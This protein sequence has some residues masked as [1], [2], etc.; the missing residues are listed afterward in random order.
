MACDELTAQGCLG[1]VLDEGR[2]VVGLR[3]VVVDGSG[4]K[5]EG[6]VR[7]ADVEPPDDGEGDEQADEVLADGTGLERALLQVLE[8]VA[9]HG[10]AL[11]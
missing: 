4:W 7:E 2:G 10:P 5:G 6:T 1:V 11:L 8:D 9:V 3:G